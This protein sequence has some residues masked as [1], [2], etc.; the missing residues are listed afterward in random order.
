[1]ASALTNPVIT[2]RGTKRI[3][4]AAPSAP[5]ATCI[6]PASTVAARRYSTPCSATSETTTSAIAPVAAEII[7]GRPPV[8]AMATAMTNDAYKPTRGSTPAMIENEI[9]SG[10]SA[11]ATTRPAS[12]ST[13]STRGVGTA[14]VITGWER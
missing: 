3:S 6:K 9:A 5:S 13:R 10:I 14:Q 1:M 8:K 12:N 2:D 4:L 11:R 7:A